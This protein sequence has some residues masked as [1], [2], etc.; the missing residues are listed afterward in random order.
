[1]IYR[2]YAQGNSFTAKD[3]QEREKW[4]KHTH[5]YS[6]ANTQIQTHAYAPTRTPTQT[7]KYPRAHNPAESRDQMDERLRRPEPQREIN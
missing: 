7:H 5:V 6:R 4:H 3:A 1:M 2:R